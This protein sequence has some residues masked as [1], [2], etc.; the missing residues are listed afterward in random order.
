[1]IWNQWTRAPIL[2]STELLFF[3]RAVMAPVEEL[4]QVEIEVRDDCICWTVEGDDLPV[5]AER[6]DNGDLSED[7]EQDIDET[8]DGSYSIVLDVEVDEGVT[9][10]TWDP[11]SGDN[12]AAWPIAWLVVT[13]LI[14]AVGAHQKLVSAAD[15]LE[16]CSGI[17]AERVVLPL[18]ALRGQCVLPTGVPK[19]LPVGRPASIVA[20]KSAVE[21]HAAW[22]ILGAQI[23]AACEQPSAEDLHPVACVAKVVK[24]VELSP[25]SFVAV[26]AGTDRVRLTAVEA[27]GRA[28][29]LM[30]HGVV[31]E[32]VPPDERVRPLLLLT[33]KSVL[34]VSIPQDN[35]PDDALEVLGK[36][37]SERLA[38]GAAEI[39]AGVLGGE[40][41]IAVLQAEASSERAMLVAE[42][43]G[44][45]ARRVSEAVDEHDGDLEA[46]RL[47]I[48]EEE[49]VA[50]RRA[51]NER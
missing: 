14:E 24:L 7:W 5:L 13:R 51:L 42:A 46:A 49:V 27:G 34:A 8:E 28:G 29:A 30:A 45:A 9:L 40:T 31:L 33:A 4:A 22:C 17:G 37:P 43:L 47:G 6:L 15:L 3:A 20:L 38:D 35:L 25:G 39:F 19:S 1:M 16:P 11:K 41:R 12:N 21:S 23:E 26:C 10:F 2:T 44:T 32:R 18:I 36:L 50:L 48:Y